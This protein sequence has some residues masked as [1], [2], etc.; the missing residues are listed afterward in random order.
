MGTL[1]KNLRICGNCGIVYTSVSFTKFIDQCPMCKSRRYE[2][3][4]IKSDDE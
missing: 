2:T 4:L 3:I 1:A